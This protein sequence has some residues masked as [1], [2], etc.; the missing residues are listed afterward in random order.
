MATVERPYDLILSDQFF[1]Y[2]RD[3]LVHAVHPEPGT[4]YSGSRILNAGT[5]AIYEATG[6]EQDIATVIRVD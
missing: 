5:G 6:V 2:G 1:F 3:G 4:L